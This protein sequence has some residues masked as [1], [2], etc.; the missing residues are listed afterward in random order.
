KMLAG[1][2]AGASPYI[3]AYTQGMSG[4]S[5]AK[6]LETA[7]ELLYLHCTAP[8]WTPE[9]FELLRTRLQAALANREK[10][11]GAAFG[12]KLEEINT[13]GHYSSKPLRPS[14]VAKLRPDVMKAFYTARFA[15]A[16]DFTFFFTGAFTLDQITPL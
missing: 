12:E 14:D 11:P 9:S 13:M 1:Q 5:S 3:S 16:A 15:N 10:S 7:L 6:D 8:N 4:S 2:T